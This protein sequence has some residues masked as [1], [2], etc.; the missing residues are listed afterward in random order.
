MDTRAPLLRDDETD[1]ARLLSVGTVAEGTYFSS[2]DRRPGYPGRM[3]DGPDELSAC[4]SLTLAFALLGKRWTAL[5]LDVLAQRPARFSELHRAV[6]NLSDRVL[7]ER[8]HE[9][10][11][12]GL[13]IRE[14][15]DHGSVTYSLTSTGADLK[16]ALDALRAWADTLAA[17]PPG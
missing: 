2:A 4:P 3:T 12:A 7:G 14:E 16:P 10:T 9:L 8:L 6:P 1:Q 15:G 11:E 5:I 17:A 13:V